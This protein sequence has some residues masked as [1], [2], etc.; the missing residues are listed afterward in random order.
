M[1]YE[2]SSQFSSKNCLGAF[3]ETPSYLGVHQKSSTHTPQFITR[4]IETLVTTGLRF[5][6]MNNFCCFIKDIL[7]E[8]ASI[9]ILQLVHG[10]EEYSDH[11]S[12]GCCPDLH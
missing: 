7:Q 3:L 9:Y 5:N 12:L 8:E 10:G 6:K 1:V 4:N 11:G 2:K